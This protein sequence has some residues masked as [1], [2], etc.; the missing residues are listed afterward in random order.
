MRSHVY[1]KYLDSSYIGETRRGFKE[2]RLSEHQAD[3]RK[4]RVT[5]AMVKHLKYPDHKLSWNNSK[6]RK[7]YEKLSNPDRK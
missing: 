3:V 5:I 7:V 6:E 4:M 1:S 2:K